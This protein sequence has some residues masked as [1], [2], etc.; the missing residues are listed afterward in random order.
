MKKATI[1][2]CLLST[3][4]FSETKGENEAPRAVV[5]S[6]KKGVVGPTQYIVPAPSDMAFIINKLDS[7]EITK[8]INTNLKSQYPSLKKYAIALGVLSTDIFYYANAED[9][10]KVYETYNKIMSIS[11]KLNV[12]DDA[13]KGMLEIKSLMIKKDWKTLSR[14]MEEI[15]I[16][17]ETQQQHNY[18][19][20]LVI[21]SIVSAWIEGL[22]IASS[23]FSQ[24]Y[25]VDITYVFHQPLLTS[26]FKRILQSTEE[27]NTMPEVKEMVKVFEYLVIMMNE[28]GNKKYTKAQVIEMAS[29]M[30]N[31]K[32]K[33][34]N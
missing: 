32:M 26:Y 34:L 14:K 25:N 17:I 8:H 27:I 31:L 16:N 29:I 12:A 30:W 15:L 23:S 5:S 20:D 10:T 22:H 9:T 28:T 3:L 6:V 1:L 4:V 11:K 33:I 7:D 2:V 24:N 19:D 13:K 18:R 21:L